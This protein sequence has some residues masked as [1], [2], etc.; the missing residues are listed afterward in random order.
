MWKEVRHN[1]DQKRYS[2][3][4]HSIETQA[5]QA[6]LNTLTVDIINPLTALKV[7]EVLLAETGIFGS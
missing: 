4:T 2:T 1:D 3:L 6:F 5:R 7:S